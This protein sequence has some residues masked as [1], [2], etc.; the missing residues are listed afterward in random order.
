MQVAMGKERF[1]YF[2]SFYAIVVPLSIIGAFIKKNH[3]LAGPA[4]PLTFLLAFQYDMTYGT[5]L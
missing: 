5:M 1:K 4:I 3:L 2:A